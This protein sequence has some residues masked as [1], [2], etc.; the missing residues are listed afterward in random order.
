VNSKLT[1]GR[2]KL[3]EMMLI[4]NR[5]NVE[6]I[7]V[8]LEGIIGSGVGLG[9]VLSFAFGGFVFSI[10]SSIECIV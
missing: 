5:L 10:R 8:S 2:S 7:I 1:T 6:V 3:T 4:L 9:L